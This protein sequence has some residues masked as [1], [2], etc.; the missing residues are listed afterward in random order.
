PALVRAYAVENFFD[1]A[2]IVGDEQLPGAWVNLAVGHVRKA[3]YAP[4][5]LVRTL[6]PLPVDP[7]K[8]LELPFVTPIYNVNGQFV[9]ADDDCPLSHSRRIP[10]H[11]SQT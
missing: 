1:L 6:G 3:L 5:E 8:L 11:Q 7:R 4:P 10:G 9:P 2:L